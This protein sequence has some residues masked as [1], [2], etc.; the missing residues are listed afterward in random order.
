VSHYLITRWNVRGFGGLYRDPDWLAERQWLFESFCLPSVR[1]QIARD[2]CWLILVDVETPPEVRAWLAG[3]DQRIQLVPVGADPRERTLAI[4]A[5]IRSG[6]GER[7]ITTRLDSDDAIADNHLHAVRAHDW[8]VRC[9]VGFEYGLALDH[10][11]G[12][13]WLRRYRFNP[14]LSLVEP[15]DGAESVH[16]KRHD[17]VRSEELMS[18]P[19][20]GW[21]QVIHGRNLANTPQGSPVP[22]GAGPELLESFGARSPDL[23]RPHGIA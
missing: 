18:L 22:A 16:V 9:F 11:T 17:R 4:R 3:C 2:F 19:A 10:R 5:V 20:I 6:S 15:R 23:A 13:L 12:Q 7:V 14:F 1:R 8:G 21:L